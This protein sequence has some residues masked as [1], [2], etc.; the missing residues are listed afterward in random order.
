MLL[1]WLDHHHHPKKTRLLSFELT[2]REILFADPP[3][4]SER[5]FMSFVK[6]HGHFAH[7]LPPAQRVAAMVPVV[8]FL[9]TSMKLS[10]RFLR[11]HP[12]YAGQEADADDVLVADAA[13]R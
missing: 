1:L 4:G 7:K 10:F 11:H 3:T 5:S 6:L 8:Q 9:R 12:H 13:L 2:S